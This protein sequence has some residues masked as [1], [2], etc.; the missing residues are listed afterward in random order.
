MGASTRIKYLFF[1]LGNLLYAKEPN[2]A[3]KVRI[4]LAYTKLIA[5]HII[6]AA[7]FN[8]T[9]THSLGLRIKADFHDT[10]CA[11]FGETFVRH[12]YYFKPANDNPLIFDCGANIGFS[13]LYFK[14]LYP[15]AKILCFEPYA[16]ARALLE[17]NIAKNK[18]ADVEIVPIALG[19]KQGTQQLYFDVAGMGGTTTIPGRIKGARTTTVRTERLSDFIKKHGTVDFVKMDIEGSE[20]EVI[21]ELAASGQI[22]NIREMVI[23]YHHCIAGQK[24]A[25]AG[26]LKTLEREGFN[27][28]LRSIY[29]QFGSWNVT[30]NIMIHAKRDEKV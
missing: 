1:D 3:K 5:Q 19:E 11:L 21:N 20:H 17:Q 4:A 29:S 10:I 12:E 16:G 26:F 27:Y 23:E 6:Y 22:R 7:R 8:V 30:Q 28:R 18:L 25:F 13:T 14:Y 2:T 24:P 9:T 15:K